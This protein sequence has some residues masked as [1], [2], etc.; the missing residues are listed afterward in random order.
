V[1]QI[2]T[3]SNSPRQQFPVNLTVNGEQL[4]LNLVIA[5]NEVSQYWVMSISDIDNNPLITDVPLL[6]GEYPSANL[7]NQYQYML[8]GSA[9]IFDVGSIIDDDY[10]NSQELGIQFVL[11]WGDNV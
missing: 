8:I 5:Y 7:L 6:T 10:P 9:Y 2:V 3:L 4:Q 11:V 1:N